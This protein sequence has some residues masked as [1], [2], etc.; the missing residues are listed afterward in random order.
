MIKILTANH[1]QNRPIRVTACFKEHEYLKQQMTELQH[2]LV[3]NKMLLCVGVD[4][5]I[6]LGEGK[7][8]RCSLRVLHRL[9]TYST[10][11]A[12]FFR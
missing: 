11:F 12:H 10:V 4:V 1:N 3:I 8:Q 5:A 2:V 7:V 9:Q 6:I